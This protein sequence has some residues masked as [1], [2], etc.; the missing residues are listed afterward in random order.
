MARLTLRIREIIRRY[1]GRIPA[2]NRHPVSFLHIF[3][4]SPLCLA[5]SPLQY[6]GHRAVSH[7]PPADWPFAESGCRGCRVGRD[8][9]PAR[10]VLDSPLPKTSRAPVRSA[11][12]GGRSPG[13]SHLRHQGLAHVASYRLDGCPP[14]PVCRSADSLTGLAGVSRSR[15][16]GGRAPAAGPGRLRV[17]TQLLP[18]AGRPSALSFR[19]RRSSKWMPRPKKSPYSGMD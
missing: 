5:L 9:A 19:L 3:E 8:A 2:K 16:S 12:R 14:L 18:G 10:P 6:L 1:T 7:C 13:C 15:R 11:R 17:P 4:S